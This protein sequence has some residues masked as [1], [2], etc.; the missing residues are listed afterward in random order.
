M[1]ISIKELVENRDI[2][3]TAT[4]YINC[5]TEDYCFKPSPYLKA[6]NPDT[7]IEGCLAWL[8]REP[9]FNRIIG[10]FVDQQLV[11]YIS[12]GKIEEEQ[13]TDC[14]CEITGFFVD[15]K[16]RNKGIGLML[17]QRAMEFFQGH[18]FEKCAIYNYQQS[19][20]NSYYQSLGGILVKQEIQNVSGMELGT[21][22]FQYDIAQLLKLLGKKL[23][24]YT[25]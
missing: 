20:A 15:K 4:I 19:A 13:A 18:G 14:Q 1:E 9:K 21:D 25:K 16:F 2:C 11:G 8:A 7:E 5:I 23:R 6:L 24:K 17:L 10:A 3:A 22:V 12:T